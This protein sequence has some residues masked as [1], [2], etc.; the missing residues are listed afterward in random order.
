MSHDDFAVEPVLGLPERLPSGESMLWQGSPEWKDL[1]WRV[2]HIRYVA[3]YFAILM[4]WNGFS[5]YWVTGSFMQGG[6]ALLAPALPAAIALTL[7]ALFA[8]W[9]AR[10][11]IYTLTDKRLVMRIGIA[12]PT[13]F[14]LPFSAIE[15]A[16]LKLK[17][18]GSGDIS[19]SLE[20]NT[21]IALLALWPHARPWRMRR[22]EPALRSVPDAKRVALLLANA[23][24]ASAGQA[25]LAAPTVD[26]VPAR[27][28]DLSA[29]TRQTIPDHK[30]LTLAR[31]LS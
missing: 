26:L 16:D 9:T 27:T 23:L 3:A 30:G 22:V 20:S 28:G 19:V 2:F 4:F 5:T 7:L 10:T 6:V 17:A 25:V 13:T 12:L 1:A 14:N 15:S 31:Q 29:A 18:H 21:R 24:S 8:Y 11:S